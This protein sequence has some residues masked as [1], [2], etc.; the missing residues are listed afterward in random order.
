VEYVGGFRNR[1]IANARANVG[2][3][4]LSLP[5]SLS[6]SLSLFLFLSRYLFRSIVQ[7]TLFGVN[8]MRKRCSLRKNLSLFFALLSLFFS[9]EKSARLNR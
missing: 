4:A 3:R 6:L 9:W 8:P 1:G 5:L 7:F 2:P